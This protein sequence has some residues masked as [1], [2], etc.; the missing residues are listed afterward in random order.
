MRALVVETLLAAL[1]LPV[2]APLDRVK[3]EVDLE[4]LTRHI[5]FTIGQLQ[6]LVNLSSLER[7]IIEVITARKGYARLQDLAKTINRPRSTIHRTLQR[8]VE[9]KLLEKKPDGTY[10]IH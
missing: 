8:L 9:K 10:T 3:V 4:T 5:S 2:D 1:I 7:R 6:A